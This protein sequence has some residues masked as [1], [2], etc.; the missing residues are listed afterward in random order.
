[1]LDSPDIKINDLAGYNETYA[2][3]WAEVPTNVYSQKSWDNV[4]T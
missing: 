3:S 4:N 2:K 1:M